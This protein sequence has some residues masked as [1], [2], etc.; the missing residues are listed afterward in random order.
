MKQL[1][2][3]GFPLKIS[4]EE[5]I[6]A[7]EFF[8]E[9]LLSK[10]L[11]KNIMLDIDFVV[12]M[13]KTTDYIATCSY[14]DDDSVKPRWFIISVDAGLSKTKMLKS[15]AHEMVHVKQYALGE[16]KYPYKNNINLNKW[17]N[18][19]VDETKIDYWELPWEIDAYGREMGLFVRF[20]EHVKMRKKTTK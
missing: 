3:T 17:L 1:N 13:C 10:R 14:E 18:T 8:E 5:V 15:L 19:V 12:D 2:I 9:S 20:K 16:L 7:I 4:K 6:Q 11:S